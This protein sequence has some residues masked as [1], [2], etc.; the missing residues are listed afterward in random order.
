MIARQVNR[1]VH[2]IITD[3]MESDG[4]LLKSSADYSYEQAIRKVLTDEF[5]YANHIYFVGV[6]V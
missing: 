5:T 3:R 6:K 1:I 4:E 2:K